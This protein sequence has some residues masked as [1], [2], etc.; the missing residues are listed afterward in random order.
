MEVFV[1]A[2]VVIAFVVAAFMVDVARDAA[3]AFDDG[4]VDGSSAAVGTSAEPRPLRARDARALAAAIILPVGLASEFTP[5]DDDAFSVSVEA[6]A[7]LLA[8]MR[9]PFVRRTLVLSA[10]DGHG[11]P[12]RPFLGSTRTHVKSLNCEA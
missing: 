10:V 12:R 9:S 4:D 11:G 7:L 5:A 6:V 3:L 8:A 2:G 1:V